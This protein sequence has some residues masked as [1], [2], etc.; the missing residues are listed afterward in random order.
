MKNKKKRDNHLSCRI[1]WCAALVLLLLLPVLITGCKSHNPVAVKLLARD[2]Q[3]LGNLRIH[4]IG[5]EK[6]TIHGC[7]NLNDRISWVQQLTKGKYTVSMHY[8]EPHSGGIISVTAGNRQ[9]P[10]TI[11]PTGSWTKYNTVELGSIKIE[12]K[13]EKKSY[14]KAFVLH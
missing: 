3:V 12:E 7:N 8:S 11:E 5:Q 4:D 1:I 14:C 10:V 6:A 2:A 9:I 13:G